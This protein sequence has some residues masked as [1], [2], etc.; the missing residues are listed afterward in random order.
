MKT[1]FSF[2]E[3]DLNVFNCHYLQLIRHYPRVTTAGGF[4][5]CE[6]QI[7]T[8]IQITVVKEL[9]NYGNI[10]F[11]QNHVRIVCLCVSVHKCVR[12]L[13]FMRQNVRLD[14]NLF[15]ISLGY[16]SINLPSLSLSL[17]L[18]IYI[19]MQISLN[20]IDILCLHIFFWIRSNSRIT[21]IVFE[22]N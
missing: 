11:G 18:Y 15:P 1:Q 5:F 2:L 21:F 22:G 16:L 17:S 6:R 3:T 14:M 10:L 8:K 7:I 9:L 20:I 12:Y 13:S 19:Y 4:D